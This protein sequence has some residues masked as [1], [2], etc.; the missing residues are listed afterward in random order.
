M[1]NISQDENMSVHL[2]TT[3]TA[4]GNNSVALTN[5]VTGCF[6]K[7]LNIKIGKTATT[8]AA[9]RYSYR[10]H[11]L[12]NNS[13]VI[14]ANDINKTVAAGNPAQDPT[15]TTKSTFFQKDQ[16]GTI[17]LRTNLNF[18]RD[19]NTTTN[20]E[21][22]NFTVLSVD[23]NTTLFNADL[24]TNKFA[25][26]NTTVN[27]RVLHYY[28]RTIAPKITVVCNS[29][30]CRTGLHSSNNN[31]I[32]ELISYTIF[33][34]GGSCNSSILPVGATQVGDIRWFANIDHDMSGQPLGTDGTIGTINEVINSG[35][36]TEISRDINIKNYETEAVI[37]YNGSLPYDAIMQM[38]SSPWLIYNETD[39]NAT[40][41][42]FIIQFTSGGGW[43]GKYEDNTTTKTNSADK[44]NRRVMW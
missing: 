29:N 30:T 5:Y 25:E 42:R 34:Q 37:Q 26:G 40:T 24:I 32:K 11:N 13:S 28:G 18:D 7:P 15:F 14:S 36:V 23:D 38:Q 12:D 39:N 19:V 16:N 33:C 9:L 10:V 27:Q 44:T 17:Q 41:N 21:D 35:R 4:E 20:P 6:A 22:I 1:A 2:N 3:V 43:S 8:N 31:K